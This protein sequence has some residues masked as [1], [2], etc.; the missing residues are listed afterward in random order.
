MAVSPYIQAGE[1]NI[2]KFEVTSNYTGE[3]VSLIGSNSFVAVSFYESLFDCTVRADAIYTDAGYAKIG[4][5]SEGKS[6][7]SGY[8]LTAGEKAEIKIMD[9]YGQRLYFEDEYHLRHRLQNRQSDPRKTVIH[10]DFCSNEFL[11]DNHRV[12]R[13]AK[14]KFEGKPSDNI[15]ILLKDVLKTPKDIKVD[16]SILNYN[17]LG[18]NEKVFYHC[19]NL[20]TKGVPETKPGV[21]AGFLFYEV[22]KDDYNNGG[23]NYRSI[24]K[25]FEQKPKRKY[26]HNETTGDVPGGYQKIINFK[27]NKTYN[28]EEAILSGFLSSNY[29]ESFDSYIKNYTVFPFNYAQQFLESNNAGKDPVQIATDTKIQED[30][31][32]LSSIFPSIGHIPT[33][34]TWEAQQPYS[35]TDDS[36]FVKSDIIKQAENRINQLFSIQITIIIPID[37]GLHVG[38]LVECNFGEISPSD[39]QDLSR[40]KSGIYM[41]MDLCHRITKKDSYTSLKLCRDASIFKK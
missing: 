26:I 2:E 29:E 37:L 6:S 25:L 31:T 4:A 21:L 8:N 17:F 30:Y 34:R 22:C 40:N 3:T 13:R 15:V 9:A 19:M 11:I 24:D 23:Y 41:I 39:I 27:E 38:D 1:A 10:S 14:T 7:S 18:Y 36:E 28:A 16:K 33:G 5:V 20:C 32:R 35:K 12:S